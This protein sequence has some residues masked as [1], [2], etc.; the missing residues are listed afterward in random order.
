MADKIQSLKSSFSIIA[1]LILHVWENRIW[2]LCWNPISC[3]NCRL[4]LCNQNVEITVNFLGSPTVPQQLSRPRDSHSVNCIDFRDEGSDV[5]D[6]RLEII[7]TDFVKVSCWLYGFTML[8]VR[9][10]VFYLC[11]FSVFCEV[12]YFSVCLREFVL[13]HLSYFC[14]FTHRYGLCS[15]G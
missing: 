15:R 3:R 7:H 11:Q 14:V 8:V 6:E 5:E 1:L 10:D 9:R 2:F 12:V 13:V 4:V